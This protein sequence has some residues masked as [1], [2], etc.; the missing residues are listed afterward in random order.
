MIVEGGCHCGAVR[1]RIEGEP[2]THALCHCTDCRRHAGAPMVSWAMFPENA[3]RTIKGAL[4]VYASSEH[5]RRHFCA[6]CGTSLFYANSQHCWNHRRRRRSMIRCAAR[7]G[8]SGGGTDR[9][10]A[11]AHGCRSSSASRPDPEVSGHRRRVG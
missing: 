3:V 1:Y 2:M 4:K 8:I 9:W 7:A 5:G 6:N 11:T 10:M